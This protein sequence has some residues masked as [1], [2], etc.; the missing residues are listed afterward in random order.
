MKASGAEMRLTNL[1]Q[2]NLPIIRTI[3]SKWN[4]KNI[5]KSELESSNLSTIH[6]YGSC[7]MGMNDSNSACDQFGRL[8]NTKNLYVND[9]SILPDNLG[10]NPQGTIMALSIR[11]A[12]KM[13]K[14][15]N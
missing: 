1:N 7:P 8:W 14:E 15:F 3:D 4:N 6:I 13:V 12:E 10:V 9:S 5:V 2:H 11:N